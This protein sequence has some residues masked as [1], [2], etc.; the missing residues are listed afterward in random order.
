M[1]RLDR[2][3]LRIP[4]L[5][6][7]VR[8][9]EEY[10]AHCVRLEQE[11]AAS[12]EREKEL[13]KQLDDAAR[14]AAVL[15]E[16]GTRLKRQ[17]GEGLA[18]EEELGRRLEG[19]GQELK[20]ALESLRRSGS[21]ETV[22]D[23]MREDWDAR[24]RSEGLFF[25]ATGEREWTPEEFYASGEKNVAEHILTDMENICQGRDPKRMRAIEIGCGAG[26]LTRAL[27]AI[28]GEVH[29]VDV[30]PEMIRMA[31]QQLAGRPNVHLYVNSGADLAVLPAG[32]YQ[33]AFSF[34]VFQHIPDRAVIESYVRDAAR[35]LEPGAL[36]KFQVEGGASQDRPPD[37]WHG[38]SFTE[39]ELRE[40]AER[41]GFECRYVE[42][43]GT[44]YCWAWLFKR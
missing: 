13:R 8:Q 43:A 9:R 10:A 5:R 11:L 23:R 44:Q 36:F 22:A 35:L 39:E 26:R 27:A 34:I 14:E 32:P 40:M 41:C 31:R 37:T 38:V 25:I 4:H 6:D 30:S 33:F 12:H 24:A 2:L 7:A 17:L 21:G 1:R 18:R 29:A 3:L 19:A 20:G 15:T 28:F 42:G 16:H